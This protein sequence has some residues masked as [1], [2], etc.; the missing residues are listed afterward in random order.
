ML[1]LWIVTVAVSPF[2]S[3]ASTTVDEVRVEAR[4]PSV[5]LLD[6]F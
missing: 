2:V 6:G 3:M 1:E 5:L 4:E